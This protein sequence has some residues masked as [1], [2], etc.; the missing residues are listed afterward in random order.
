M[1][2]ITFEVPGI[3]CHHCVAT[4]ERV[5]GELDGV[6][7]VEGDAD[8]KRLAVRFE[9]PASREAIVA[10]MTEWDYPPAG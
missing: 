3:S 5:V 10:V 2:Q 9:S 8:A 6:L 4:L 1:E 7:A